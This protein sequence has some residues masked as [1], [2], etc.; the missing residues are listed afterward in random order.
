M[1]NTMISQDLTEYAETTYQKR[2][3]FFGRRRKGIEQAMEN[4]PP[5]EQPLMKFLYGTMPLS[6]VG[7]YDFSVFHAYVSHALYLLDTMAWCKELPEEIFLHYVLYHRI[8]SEAIEDC[9]SFFF[10]QLLPRI[11][12][13]PPI[14]AALT[15]NYWCA[16][17][18][19]YESSD[20]RTI[21]P[22]TMYRSGKGR[23]GE[24]SVF[25]VTAFR[26]VGIPARQVYTPRWAHCDDNHAWVEIYVE[27]AWHFLGACEPEEVL[28]KGW[29][30]HAS[31][32]ALLVHTLTFSPWPAQTPSP[33][34]SF[35]RE[36]ECL[37][38]ENPYLDR[39]NLHLDQE[40]K[41]LDCENSYTNQET[42]YI[43]REGQIAYYN[44]TAFYAKTRKLTIIIQ[45]ETG[46]PIPRARVLVEIFN[47]A[48]YSSAAS[49]L[50]DEQGKTE[51]TLGMGTVHLHAEKDG[52]WA[53]TLVSV[54]DTG[55]V[56]LN[57]PLS[58][59]WNYKEN[60]I[61]SS[62]NAVSGWKTFTIQAPSDF[63]MHQA[64]LSPQQK[65][66]NRRRLREAEILR[67]NRICGYYQE[68]LARNYP[69]ETHIL[70]A[71]AGNFQE[72][73]RFL[74]RDE[75]ADRRALLYHLS[76]KDYK[77]ARAHLL[78]S[79]LQQASRFRKS[80]E[81]QEKRDI[82]VRYLLCP[83][84]YLEELSD[85]R[86]YIQEYFTKEQKEKFSRNPEAIWSYIRNTI[87]NHADMDYETLY[88][89]PISCLELS[90]GHSLSQKILFV[91]ICRTLGIPARL[92]PV[93]L[94]AEW[95]HQNG[96]I[97]VTE[98]KTAPKPALLTLIGTEGCPWQ[99]YQHWTI[100]QFKGSRFVTL[101][102]TG[103]SISGEK[104]ELLLSPGTYRLLIS[105][106]LPNGNQNA[107]EYVFTLKSG[108]HQEISMLSFA[109]EEKDRLVSHQLEDFEVFPQESPK[110][111]P[112]APEKSKTTPGL[113]TEEPKTTPELTTKT[114]AP[115]RIS[116]LLKK[117]TAVLAFLQEGQEPTEHVLNEL[118]EQGNLLFALDTQIIF[119]LQNRS[120]LENET[121][122]KVFEKF[123]QIQ[124][125]YAD[126]DEA[127][128]PVARRMYLEPEKYPLLAVVRPT[129]EAIYGNSGY[130]VGIVE[131]LSQILR[132]ISA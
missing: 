132:C 111:F 70:R 109:L 56:L 60:T 8:N 107:A 45:D 18:G 90:H 19:S 31:S 92:H 54:E 29:F 53:E 73:Y 88:S 40:N 48:E 23:C 123:P 55:Q 66:K 131:L 118:L 9:R 117:K 34:Y 104:I 57:L 59:F 22:L 95:Y 16:E 110:S 30:S 15:I 125:V 106:R 2:L 112:S 103:K 85:Y 114:T 76:P 86:R 26:S 63:P 71:A 87:Q 119:L 84:I 79:H 61:S 97:S 120:A 33:S 38:Q 108:Q 121:L 74:S 51:I 13:L 72:I 25:A 98:K 128:E 14:E 75:S 35:D 36:N 62:E 69:C 78:E 115:C 24:E 32:R 77:D 21:S 91:A 68:D 129:M 58:R 10:R 44:R 122:Q 83:R 6:D 126:F 67:K 41:Y 3:P 82:Y 105:S 80:W 47:M 43:G 42:E 99:Y 27:G 17:N 93:T 28:D 102:Y 46:K 94:E 127:A 52:C 37:G 101:D 100:G 96:F 49:L 12:G 65:K 20:S 89:T 81:Q 39:E 130:H 11:Q 64:I 116:S 50:T 7:T 1:E 124:T 5:G 113:T 4:L